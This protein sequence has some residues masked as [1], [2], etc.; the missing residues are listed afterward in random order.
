MTERSA[1]FR[2]FI[3]HQ[4]ARGSGYRANVDALHLAEFA[5]Q[6]GSA[7]KRAFDLGAGAGAVGLTLLHQRRAA[8]VVFVEVDPEAARLAARN[9]QESG[10]SNRGEVA[11]GEVGAVSFARAGEADLVVCNP[12]YIDPSRGRVPPEPRRARA[13]SG[14]L[15]TFVEAARRFAGKRSRICF[16][17]PANDLATLVATLRAAGIE[18]KRLRMVHPRSGRPAR[19]VLVEGRAGKIGGLVVEPPLIEL[20]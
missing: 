13:R 9:I 18:P 16:V 8:H 7:A 5:G 19:I 2:D 1:A 6:G 15:T 4:P 10:W 3:F 11:L 12:P 14:S 20:P 17:Y